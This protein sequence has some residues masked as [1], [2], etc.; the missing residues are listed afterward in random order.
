MPLLRPYGRKV[1]ENLFQRIDH[2]WSRKVEA[3]ESES[4]RL[5][6]PSIDGENKIDASVISKFHRQI[7]YL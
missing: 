5:S 7:D 2:S 6:E 3:E 4:E 1:Q